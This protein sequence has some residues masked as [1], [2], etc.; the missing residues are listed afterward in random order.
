MRQELSIGI[1]SDEIS[2]DLAEAMRYA[3]LWGIQA[4]E[5]RCLG[6]GRVPAVSNG[7]L[8]ELKRAVR[9]GTVRVSALSPGV[10]KG[11]LSEP[12]QTAEELSGTLPRTIDQ[13]RELGAG[14]VIVFG[15]KRQPDG[16]PSEFDAVADVLRTAALA[17]ERSGVTLAVEN[18]PG[19][20]C[21]TGASTA[22]MIRAVG[23]KALRAN[24]DPCNALGTGEVPYPD[25]YNAIKGYIANVHV[26]D[27]VTN[28]LISCVPV[29]EGVIDWKGQIG[30]LLDD[31]IVD[32][33]TI[34]THCQPLIERSLQNLNT[35]RRYISDHL[36]G[37]P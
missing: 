22:R 33:V 20:W 27:T 31:G 35:L 21:D 32:H 19:Y 24:W 10:F 28:S 14:T 9:S 13:A 18:E 34:E 37:R 3:E 2:P 12:R 36:K 1:L 11:S 23:S 30:A 29:G 7:E 8:A 5:I 4:L 15:F 6:S 17:A 16:P 25:G 26:K